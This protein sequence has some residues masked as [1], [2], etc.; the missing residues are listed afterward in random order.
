MFVFMFIFMFNLLISAEESDLYCLKYGKLFII[1]I[2]ILYIWDWLP[3]RTER[4]FFALQYT[5]AFLNTLKS[6]IP[7]IYSS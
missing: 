7:C 4:D 5:R 1:F 2:I 3:F 6:A